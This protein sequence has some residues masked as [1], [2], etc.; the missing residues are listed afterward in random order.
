MTTI[1]ASQFSV[2]FLL[3]IQMMSDTVDCSSTRQEPGMIVG[4]V[5]SIAFALNDLNV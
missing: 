1:W 3:Y 2:L 4:E 5:T